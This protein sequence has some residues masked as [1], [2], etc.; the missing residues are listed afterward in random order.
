[1]YVTK[2]EMKIYIKADCNIDDWRK[3]SF[4]KTQSMDTHKCVD[5]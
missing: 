2:L 1:M 5:A 4:A 3:P